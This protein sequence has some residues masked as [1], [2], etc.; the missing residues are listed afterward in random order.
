[1]QVLQHKRLVLVF[2]KYNKKDLKFRDK[3]FVYNFDEYN[4][5]KKIYEPYLKIQTSI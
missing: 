2:I 5:F 3:N 4:S 1:M